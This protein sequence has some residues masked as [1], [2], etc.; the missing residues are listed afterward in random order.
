MRHDFRD[1]V[2]PR[3]NDNDSPSMDK[4]KACDE[5]SRRNRNTNRSKRISSNATSPLWITLQRPPLFLLYVSFYAF[6]ELSESLKNNTTCLVASVHEKVEGKIRTTARQK[7]YGA[8]KRARQ[9]MIEMI[10]TQGH[11]I[12]NEM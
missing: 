8:K 10:N 1:V 2:R 9:K 3:D 12:K 5:I 6:A 4:A 7:K 11:P